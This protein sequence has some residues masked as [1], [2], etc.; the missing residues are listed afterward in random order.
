MSDYAGGDPDRDAFFAALGRSF[1]S[2]PTPVRDMRSSISL[3]A[4]RW[5]ALTSKI[6]RQSLGLGLEELSQCSPA[7]A[8][9]S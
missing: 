5:P 6:K 3:A 9:I 7:P 2:F 8:A 1:R 4:P